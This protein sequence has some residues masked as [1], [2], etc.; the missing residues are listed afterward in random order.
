MIAYRAPPTSLWDQ[1]LLSPK[2]YYSR[3]NMLTLKILER[4]C[5]FSPDGFFYRFSFLTSF[6]FQK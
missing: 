3:K 6:H 4:I 1:I 5:D 2:A